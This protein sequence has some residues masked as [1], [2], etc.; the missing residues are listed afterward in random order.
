MSPRRKHTAE[1]LAFAFIA[2]LAVT[3]LILIF[4][5]CTIAPKPVA[6]AHPSLDGNTANS[7]LIGRLPDGS[8]EITKNAVLRYNGLIAAGYGSHFIPP[9]KVNDGT[10]PLPDGDVRIDAQHLADFAEMATAYRSGLK[11]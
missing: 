8:F 7:G 2:A 1:D 5:G 10:A 6:A 3:V 11:P 4:A 9:L